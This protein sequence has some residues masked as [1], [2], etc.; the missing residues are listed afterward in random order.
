MRQPSRQKLSFSSSVSRQFDYVQCVI[1]RLECLSVK[2]KIAGSS[3]ARAK[4]LEENSHCPPSK[5][6]LINFREG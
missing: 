3:P 2:R 4:R 1:E 5:W 6:Y